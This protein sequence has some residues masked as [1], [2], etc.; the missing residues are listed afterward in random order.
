[1]YSLRFVP[2]R[3]F[4]IV[5]KLFIYMRE[6]FRG[7]RSVYIL[8]SSGKLGFVRDILF[9]GLARIAGKRIVCHLKSGRYDAYNRQNNALVR[10]FVRWV[11]GMADVVIVLSPRFTS[12]F[13][14]LDKSRTAVVPILNGLPDDSLD[15]VYSHVNSGSSATQILYLSNLMG[16]KGYWDLLN[17]AVILNKRTDMPDWNLTL[18]GATIPDGVEKHLTPDKIAANVTDFIA[19]NGLQDVVRWNGPVGGDEKIAVLA[20]SDILVLPSAYPGE[21][22]PVSIIEGIASGLAVLA[23]DYRAIPDM[24]ESQVN[25]EYIVHGDPVGLAEILAGLIINS[26]KLEQYQAASRRIYERDFSWKTHFERI[27]PVILGDE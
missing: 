5:R 13:D 4:Q 19:N 26:D 1:M 22:Q 7:H 18:A 17:A 8:I 23:T 11:I 9:I 20:E 27:R 12:L 6:L 16:T 15:C 21:G 3:F 14:F 10:R 24:L 25:G 2:L